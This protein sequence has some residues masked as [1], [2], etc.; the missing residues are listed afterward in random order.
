ML[1]LRQQYGAQSESLAAR[2]L[3]RR[4]YTILET[5]YRTPLGE[6]DIIAR[7]RDT[8]VFVEV[9]ARRSLGFGG[10]KWAVTP[11]KQRKISMVALYYLKTTRQSQA[12]AR[13]D[14]VAIRSLAEPPQVE[15]IQNDFDLLYG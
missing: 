6:I 4:G 15:I 3:K 8:I 5:N 2:L 13:F 14:V 9:K 1:N 11:K 12:K 7:D 10:P